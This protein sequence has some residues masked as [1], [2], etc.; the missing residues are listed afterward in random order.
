MPVWKFTVKDGEVK[1]FNWVEPFNEGEFEAEFANVKPALC[2]QSRDVVATIERSIREEFG[3]TPMAKAA[4]A[5]RSSS[6]R[7][8][9]YNLSAF[10][11]KVEDAT[12]AKMKKDVASLIAKGEARI[13]N[14]EKGELLLE[15]TAKG[16]RRALGPTNGDAS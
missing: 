9:K 15:L 8:D 11:G 10:I 4:T 2:L 12:D 13:V 16:W 7:S 3:K 5:I 6:S 1:T 14:N